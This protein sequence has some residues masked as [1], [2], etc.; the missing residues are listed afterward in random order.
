MYRLHPRPWTPP[1]KEQ[2][3]QGPGAQPSA[4]NPAHLLCSDL[5]PLP[6]AEPRSSHDPTSTFDLSV[7]KT[8]MSKQLLKSARA[9]SLGRRGP[10]RSRLTPSVCLSV[11]I[12]SVYT[13]AT[14]LDSP[15]L[16][17]IQKSRQPHRLKF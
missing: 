12:Y 17:L 10:F 11:S 5:W 9:G 8:W 3:P 4:C 2:R 7:A 13:S 1:R 6:G 15:P 14:F 16:P